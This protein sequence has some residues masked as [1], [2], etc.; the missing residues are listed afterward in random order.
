MSTLMH[1]AALYQI[2][3]IFKWNTDW[4]HNESIHKKNISM[5]SIWEKQIVCCQAALLCI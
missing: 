3:C 1:D 2:E 5:L 4:S